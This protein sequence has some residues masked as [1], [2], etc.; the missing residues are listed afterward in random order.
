MVPT[1]GHPVK[2]K[3]MQTAKGSVVARRWEEEG[4]N[5]QNTEFLGQ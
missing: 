5:K 4:M 2:G 1:T 3:T